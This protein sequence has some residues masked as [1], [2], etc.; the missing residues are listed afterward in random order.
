MGCVL[1]G[2]VTV[3]VGEGMYDLRQLSLWHKAVR[4]NVL[5]KVEERR[6]AQKL[7]CN[8]SLQMSEELIC[9]RDCDRANGLATIAE[10]HDAFAAVRKLIQRY[11]SLIQ[12]QQDKSNDYNQQIH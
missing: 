7:G 3:S 11:K 4:A 1:L 10:P 6:Y 9:I 8:S 12:V 2:M 5:W